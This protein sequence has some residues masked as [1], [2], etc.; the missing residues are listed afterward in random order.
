MKINEVN[1]LKLSET[2][3]KNKIIEHKQKKRDNK[4]FLWA[5]LIFFKSKILS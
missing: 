5:L 4:L 1:K 2:F 3:I